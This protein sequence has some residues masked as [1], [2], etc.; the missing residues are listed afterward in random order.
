M[1]GRMTN[2]KIAIQD[3]PGQLLEVSRIISECG[4]NII[5]VSH[6]RANP[7]TQLTDCFMKLSLETRDRE[8]IGQIRKQLEQSGFHLVSE[9]T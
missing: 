7:K 3:R 9:N 1:S 5:T 4:A 6:D 8:Q 2:M